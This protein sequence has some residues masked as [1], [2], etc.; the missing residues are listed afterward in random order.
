MVGSGL[1]EDLERKSGK[2]EAE[3]LYNDGKLYTAIV[4]KGENLY[5]FIQHS[6]DFFYV[7][8]LDDLHREYFKYLFSD[9]QNFDNFF[10]KEVQCWEYEK[11]S[12]KKLRTEI[13]QF[14]EKGD[15][16]IHKVSIPTR[17][18]IR[19]SSIEPIDVQGFYEDYP[20]FGQY[21]RLI[22][23]DR[24]DS[25]NLRSDNFEQLP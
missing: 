8:F 22:R 21:D 4:E 12:D 19:L 15:I 23:L 13:F 3:Q 5:S 10:L 24:M 18:S 14:T 9:S 17:K 25:L 2:Y 7:G 20:K 6:D 16:T 11:E 1:K